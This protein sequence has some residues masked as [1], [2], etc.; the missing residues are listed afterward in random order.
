MTSNGFSVIQTAAVAAA[1]IVAGV[2]ASQVA[3]VA[4]VPLG[5][6]VSGG[7]APTDGGVLTGPLRAPAGPRP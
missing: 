5:G 4:G 6:A 2:A 1:I 3:L 7:N